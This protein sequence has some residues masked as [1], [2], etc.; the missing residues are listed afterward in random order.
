MGKH[1]G[2][3]IRQGYSRVSFA[4]YRQKAPGS[5]AFFSLRPPRFKDH[6][7]LL[8]VFRIALTNPPKNLGSLMV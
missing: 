2:F 5:G 6:P 3:E 4:A 1:E 8:N 7:F